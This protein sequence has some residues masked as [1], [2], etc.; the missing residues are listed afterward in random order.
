MVSG[1]GGEASAVLKPNQVFEDRLELTVP[2]TDIL[3]ETNSLRESSFPD[4]STQEFQEIPGHS[5]SVGEM[6]KRLEND[7]TATWP[8]CLKLLGI[9]NLSQL[10]DQV[11]AKEDPNSHQQSYKE[12]R[13]SKKKEAEKLALAKARE[14]ASTKKGIEE[15]PSPK[16][17]EDRLVKQTS[18]AR[19]LVEA[20]ERRETKERQID[21]PP[22]IN[23]QDTSPMDRSNSDIIAQSAVEQ[24]R[25]NSLSLRLMIDEALLRAQVIEVERPTLAINEPPATNIKSIAGTTQEP[26]VAPTTINKISL[27]SLNRSLLEDGLAANGL[28]RNNL[29]SQV[30]LELDN[31]SE[32]GLMPVEN[33]LAMVDQIMEVDTGVDDQ[34]LY[35]DL[36]EI[37]SELDLDSIFSEEDDGSGYSSVESTEIDDVL[38]VFEADDQQ[39]ARGASVEISSES[40]LVAKDEDNSLSPD[41]AVADDAHVQEQ[42]TGELAAAKPLV[43][44]DQLLAV[45]LELQ[46]LIES[47]EPDKVTS[48][49]SLLETLIKTPQEK[50]AEEITT[51]A[52]EDSMQTFFIKVLDILNLE[53]SENMLIKLL[54]ELS[55]SVGSI[56]MANDQQQQQLSIDQ[57]NRIG[58][59]E[60]KIAFVSKILASLVRIIKSKLNNL[61]ISSL[62]RLAISLS[63][64]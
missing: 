21:K 41:L 24:N 60:Y 1:V 16:K 25:R 29:A 19:A 15:K 5:G 23:R 51:V 7:P 52:S 26:K 27:P 30:V 33:G 43:E 31:D 50:K 28:Q 63:L 34:E 18:V 37:R 54:E 59:K 44:A 13:E 11:E 10:K 48:I 17:E 3:T 8:R 53:Y 9:T 64:T 12:Y 62:G 45:R 46:Q 40:S 4:I 56:E 14:S 20:I 47:L 42:S 57:L 55:S 35:L 39:L 58:T 49:Y 61:P 32:T 6:V 36:D 2:P 38:T 22:K